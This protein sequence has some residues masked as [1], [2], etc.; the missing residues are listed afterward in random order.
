MPDFEKLAFPSGNHLVVEAAVRDCAIESVVVYADRAQV[1]RKVPVA[2]AT[3]RNEV[4]VYG[5]SDCVD[6]NSIR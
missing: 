6:Q 1:K 5:L 2:L 4:V 3:G